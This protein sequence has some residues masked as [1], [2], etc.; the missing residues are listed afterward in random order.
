M[1]CQSMRLGEAFHDLDDVRYLLR[2][3]NVGSVAAALEIVTRYFDEEALAPRI[4]LALEG[5]L[6]G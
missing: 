2:Y 6:P 1:K 4:R 3:L 5:M